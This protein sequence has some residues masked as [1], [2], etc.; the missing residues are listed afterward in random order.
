[1]NPYREI[2][3]EVSSLV[4]ESLAVNRTVISDAKEQTGAKQGPHHTIYW[5]K[6]AKADPSQVVPSHIKTDASKQLYTI[7]LKYTGDWEDDKKC[8]FGTQ[9]WAKG[10]KYEGE[11]R[12][13]QRHGKGTFW[14]K[15]KGQLTKQYTGDWINDKRTGRGLCYYEDG[16][17]Y[18]GD[19]EE[20]KRHGRG[21]QTY[22]DQSIYEGEWVNDQR[23]GLGV[24]VGCKLTQCAPRVCFN[25]L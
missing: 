23:A 5:V 1:M 18:E 9:T 14:V 17:K 25:V 16:S 2:D 10:H 12:D 3:H 6:H 4:A 15:R 7:G 24:L 19:W 22:A 13:N 11:W 8:G 20:N 21:K